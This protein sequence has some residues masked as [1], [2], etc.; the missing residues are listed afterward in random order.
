MYNISCRLILRTVQIGYCEN[1]M[2]NMAKKRGKKKK[3]ETFVEK[4][5]VYECEYLL[6]FVTNVLCKGQV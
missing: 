6:L 4:Y 2:L 3:E 1:E 5:E